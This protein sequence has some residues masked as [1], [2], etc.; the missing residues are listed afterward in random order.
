[1]DVVRQTLHIREADVGSDDAAFVAERAHQ[2]LERLLV[3][4]KVVLPVVV[5]VDVGPAVVGEPATDHRVSGALHL[6]G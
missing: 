3:R 2:V 6:V 4:R 1:M 5:E